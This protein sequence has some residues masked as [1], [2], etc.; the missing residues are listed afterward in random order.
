MFGKLT[1]SRHSLRPADPA[2]QPLLIVLAVVV[3]AT[4]ALDHGEGMH[5]SYLW[6]RMADLGRS[7]ADRR[8]VLHPRRW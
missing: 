7:Q 1:W 8:H 4:L 6:S 3:F 2:G 5:W